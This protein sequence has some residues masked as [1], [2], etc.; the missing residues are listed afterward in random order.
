MLREREVYRLLDNAKQYYSFMI[1]GV[2]LEE[3]NPYKNDCV[4]QLYIGNDI[5]CSA[6]SDKE[7][8]LYDLAYWF[9]FNYWRLAYEDVPEDEGI[10]TLD[11]EQSHRMT[12]VGKG[13]IWPDLTFIPDTDSA[14]MYVVNASENKSWKFDI[15]HFKFQIFNFIT[16][17]LYAIPK[18]ERVCTHLYTVW[19]KLI[20]DLSDTE[21]T[22]KRVL[23]ALRH[24]DQDDFEEAEL[25]EEIVEVPRILIEE[26]TKICDALC[27][28]YYKIKNG[29]FEQKVIANDRYESFSID[30][31]YDSGNKKDPSAHVVVKC[32]DLQFNSE[33]STVVEAIM[34]VR[35]VVW[36]EAHKGLVEK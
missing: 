13:Y 8:P 9:A 18:Q 36:S 4:L 14:M 10:I 25:V 27:R 30:A 21:R 35:E 11:W 33:G 7:Y 22:T 5:I 1:G 23:E 20:A 2:S 17:V 15:S 34:K 6:N 26:A 24:K 12:A 31:K 28:M 32:G 29:G 19:N 3:K 16:N